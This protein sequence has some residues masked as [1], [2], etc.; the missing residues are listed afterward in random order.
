ML[1]N[2]SADAR[3]PQST[4]KMV[5]YSTTHQTSM[6]LNRDQQRNRPPRYTNKEI[7]QIIDEDWPPSGI[8]K[9][10]RN[11]ETGFGASTFVKQIKSPTKA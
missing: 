1:I 7:D 6:T 2:T 5:M 11:V 10:E 4:G 9:D 8:R 3:S